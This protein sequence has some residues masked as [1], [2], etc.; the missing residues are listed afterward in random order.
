MKKWLAALLVFAVILTGLT[1]CSPSE[2]DLLEGKWKAT[3]DL[4]AAFET[5][6]AADPT[7]ASCI[8]LEDFQVEMTL[9]FDGDGTY[10]WTVDEDDL[11]AGAQKM[12]TAIADGL[13]IYLESA[14]GMPAE[15][16]LAASGL[17]LDEVMATY[18]DTD[19]AQT[20][21]GTLESEGTWKLDGGKLTLANEDGYVVFEGKCTVDEEELKLK[22][23]SGNDLIAKLLPLTFRRS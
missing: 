19:I 22:S 1:G 15:D 4:A 11:N 8:D 12:M 14:I 5:M 6:L 10:R 21:R 9:R 17:T 20:I 13:S 2:E 23:A 7:L 18:F 3:A 16:A